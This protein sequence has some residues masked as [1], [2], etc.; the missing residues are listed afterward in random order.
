MRSKYIGVIVASMLAVACSSGA[1]QASS[2]GDRDAVSLANEVNVASRGDGSPDDTTPA[3]AR[4]A[5]NVI[6]AQRRS[7]ATNAQLIAEFGGNPSAVV[8][9]TR[10]EYHFCPE[11]S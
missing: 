10:A 5:A 11:Y 3:G 4:N 9:V 2:P 1:A 8:Y 7:N 6:C